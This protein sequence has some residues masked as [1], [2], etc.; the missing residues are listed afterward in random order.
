MIIPRLFILFSLAVFLTQPSMAHAQDRVTAPPAE[1]VLQPTPAKP[2]PGPRSGID[3]DK[4]KV[5]L[6]E[7]LRLLAQLPQAMQD[8]VTAEAEDMGIYCQNNLMLRNFYDCSCFSMR[9]MR[10]R[11]MQGPDPDMSNLIE[12]TDYAV[13]AFEPAIANYGYE[14]CHDV[15]Y[16]DRVSDKYITDMC[17]CTGRTLATRFTSRPVSSIT[18]ADNLFNAS[19]QA[20]RER[21]KATYQ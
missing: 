18:Y 13:C 8:E 12:A 4:R 15:I 21:L 1:E 7:P 9:Y 11:I 17:S 5:D 14:R 16:M 6:E 2:V 19:M 10:E 3:Q 20:C